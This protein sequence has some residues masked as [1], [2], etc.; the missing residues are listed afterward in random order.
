MMLGCDGTRETGATTCDYCNRPIETDSQGR[1]VNC[2]AQ[3]GPKALPW[4]P[5][6]G[7]GLL[8]RVDGPPLCIRRAYDSVSDTYAALSVFAYEK[9]RRW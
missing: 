2:G 3:H 7:L 8:H 6:T 1:C 4:I 9:A 5:G